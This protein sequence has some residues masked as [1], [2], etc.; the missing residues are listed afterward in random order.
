MIVSIQV[1]DELAADLAQA[2]PSRV[3]VAPLTDRFPGIDVVDAYA[4]Q[5]I[6]IRQWVAEAPG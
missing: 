5:L 3:P 2:E 4:I 6:N 1:R